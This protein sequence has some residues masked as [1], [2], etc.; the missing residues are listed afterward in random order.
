MV[1]KAPGYSKYRPCIKWSGSNHCRTEF[2]EVKPTSWS[3][4][5]A[6]NR[7]HV[8]LVGIQGSNVCIGQVFQV[9]SSANRPFCELY[10]NGKDG[11]IKMGVATCPWG[12][13]RRLLPGYAVAGDGTPRGPIFI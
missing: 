3:P 12:C 2:H 8:K 11:S 7:L 9:G 4:N 13:Q 5:D 1:M 10:Y 6:R